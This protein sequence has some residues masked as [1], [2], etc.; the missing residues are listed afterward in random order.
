[1]FFI[2][3]IEN[4]NLILIIENISIAMLGLS[5]LVYTKERGLASSTFCGQLTKQWWRRGQAVNESD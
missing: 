3:S 5:D 4:Q 2:V 1:M